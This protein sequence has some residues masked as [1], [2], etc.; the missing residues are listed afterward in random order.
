MGFDPGAASRIPSSAAT[1]NATVAKASP[2]KAVAVNGV[3]TNAA[4]RW[5][6]FYDM[7]TTPN[8]A[9]D[10]PVLSI[11]L[12]ASIPFNH[13]L[14]SFNFKVGVAYALVTGA[15]DNDNTAVG[16]GDVLGL[17]VMYS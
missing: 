2:G 15:A 11:A 10:V 3:N 8:P 6:K 7:A 4:V 17:N 12:A 9:V 14:Y 13:P 5:L 16:A 1:N